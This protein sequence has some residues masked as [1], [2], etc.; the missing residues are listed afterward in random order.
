MRILIKGAKII[1]K[2]SD[3]NGEIKDIFIDNGIITKIDDNL[4]VDADRTIE[5]ENL[6]LSTGGLILEQILKILV[7]NT[8]KV[9]NLYLTLLNLVDLLVFAQQQ[10]L[11]HLFLLKAK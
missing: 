3:F 9:L 7:L 4:S 10:Q 8:K 1:D 6:H 2:N 5:K 11:P